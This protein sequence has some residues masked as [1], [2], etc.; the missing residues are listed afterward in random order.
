M[1]SD[2]NVEL[3]TQLAAEILTLFHRAKLTATQ[4]HSLLDNVRMLVDAGEMD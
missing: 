1:A 4:A 2:L 3:Q